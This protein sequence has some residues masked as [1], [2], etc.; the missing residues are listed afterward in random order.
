MQVTLLEYGARVSSILFP[1]NGKL[2][3]MT[4][5][6]RDNSQ[7]LQDDYYLGASVGRVCNRI[8]YGQ[9]SL[10][11]TN[12]QLNRNSSLHCLHGGALGFSQ[13]YWQVESESISE[14]SIIFSLL[15]KEGEQGFPGELMVKVK[16]TLT[17]D[18]S[19]VIDFSA[20]PS[21]ATLVNLCNHCY[22]HLGNS[23]INDLELS[24]NAK[25]FLP[26]DNSGIPLGKAEFIANSDF[27]F[28]K[29]KL[30]FDTLSKSNEPQILTNKGF[31]H[32]YVLSPVKSNNLKANAVLSSRRSGV[33][34][35]VF[36][37]Q[38]GLQL[39]T[40]QYL[41]GD[42]EPYQALC[43]EAQHFPDAINNPYLNSPIVEAGNLYSKQVRYQFT[44]V[45]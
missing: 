12:Y 18:N 10:N 29:E 8:A 39:Y 40:G 5:G 2:T 43:L 45:Q 15:S 36:T 1:V 38:L 24:I 34:L 19:L 22:F 30:V 35:N 28:T 32:C 27:D 11:G 7:Y 3:E 42:F 37:D 13:Q 31:D 25:E 33:Q 9:F 4:L 23:S 17:D 41:S 6:Y 21:T 26:I 44:Q 14:Q 16:Y 20:Q